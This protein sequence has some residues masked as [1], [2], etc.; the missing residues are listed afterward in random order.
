MDLKK[1]VMDLRVAHELTGRYP[2]V[3]KI[4]FNTGH[5][6]E[7]KK[8]YYIITLTKNKELKFQALSRFRYR[9]LADLDFSIDL[10]KFEKYTYQIIGK[11][12]KEI[13][14]INDRDFLPFCFFAGVKT[15]YEGE[16][17]IAYLCKEFEAMGIP[18]TNIIIEKDKIKKELEEKQD[19]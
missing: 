8:G 10:T 7:G 14:L 18:E 2:V 12:F 17:N 19:L 11:N 5:I 16:N 3:V 6:V 1:I 4:P 13:R 9:H 15:S